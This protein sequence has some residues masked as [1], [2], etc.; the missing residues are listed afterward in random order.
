MRPETYHAIVRGQR[1]GIGALAARA[2]FRVASWP[3]GLAMRIRNA[4]F[5]RGWKRTFRAAVP[6]VSVGNLTLGGT[7]KTPCVEY[8]ATLLRD[9]GARPVILS[10]GYGAEHNL[11]DEAMVLEENLPDVPHLQG[12]DRVALA[13]AAVEEL[14]A[15]VLVLDD[16]FQHRRLLRDLDIVLLDA[17]WPLARESIFPRGLLR[18]PVSGLKRADAIVL[19]RCDQATTAHEQ[20]AWLKRRFPAKLVAKAIHAPLELVGADDARESLDALAGSPVA[21]FCGIGNPEAFRGT[22]E[23]LGAK[24]VA[25]RTYADH[26]TYTREDVAGLTRWAN[27]LPAGAIVL[28]TQKDWV[29]LRVADLGGRRLWALRIGFQLIEGETEIAELIE[30]IHHGVTEDAE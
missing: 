21:A 12:A 1:R 25:F 27:D 26:H 28:T 20:A 13:M 16:G 17:T 3:Y 4:L 14:D 8:V 7:G 11:N 19:T 18:E 23:K 2:G 29:K 5:D 22:L 24:P 30:R 10:R 9:R 15:E 6:V